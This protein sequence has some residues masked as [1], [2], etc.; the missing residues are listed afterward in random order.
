MV[1]NTDKVDWRVELL[2]RCLVGDAV[3]IDSVGHVATAVDIIPLVEPGSLNISVL[4]T[5]SEL[6]RRQTLSLIVWYSVSDSAFLAPRL[7]FNS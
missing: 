1:K 4:C 2:H 6:C 5:G 7:S 3:M